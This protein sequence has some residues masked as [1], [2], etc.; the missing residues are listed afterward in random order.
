MSEPYLNKGARL[1]SRAEEFLRRPYVISGDISAEQSARY[2]LHE[3]T[4]YQIELE[5]QNAELHRRNVEA[6]DLERNLDLERKRYASMFNFCPVGCFVT[7]ING[8]IL[9]ANSAGARMLG[10]EQR[11][12]AGMFIPAFCTPAGADQ[13]YVHMRRA[14]K[15]DAAER[16]SLKMVIGGAERDALIE[17]A[18]ALEG[19]T[20]DRSWRSTL[21][22][23]TTRRQNEAPLRRGEEKY[24]ATFDGSP[25]SI[26]ELDLSSVMDRVRGLRDSGA[27]DL[28][29]FLDANGA[30]LSYLGTLIRIV[31]F[32]E[33]TMEMLGATDR[34]EVRR[35]LSNLP[36]KASFDA[37]RELILA[38]SSGALHF[39]CLIPVTNTVSHA[40][41]RIWLACNLSVQ[42]RHEKTF[43][44]VI[45]TFTDITRYKLSGEGQK[46][47]KS[48][49]LDDGE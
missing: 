11:R 1:R 27:S 23:I 35:N 29:A 7:D 37:F 13:F 8:K 41:R 25:V 45:V 47:R 3:L 40:Y 31:D 15:S 9:E 14:E 33:T 44:K 34:G 26:W 39:D 16:S 5:A 38:L 2:L 48:L 28:R 46:T 24:R 43:D 36:T 30:E 4:L 32:N 6:L 10:V 42:A 20:N 22:D 49:S 18:P 21:V 12:L 19:Q 17:T